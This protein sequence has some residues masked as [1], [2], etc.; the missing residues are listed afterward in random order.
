MSLATAD[1]AGDSK[2]I[3]HGTLTA[4]AAVLCRPDTG[5]TSHELATPAVAW[6]PS[7]RHG[8]DAVHM[9]KFVDSADSG[10]SALHDALVRLGGDWAVEPA[11]SARTQPREG[12]ASGC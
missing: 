12:C 9:S 10:G 2:L 11:A 7:L 6:R 1:A 4:S 3:A 8:A 5:R